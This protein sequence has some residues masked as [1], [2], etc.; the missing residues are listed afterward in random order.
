V[1]AA[2]PESCDPIDS[3]HL[4]PAHSRSLPIG[5]HCIALRVE[6]SQTVYCSCIGGVLPCMRYSHVA[7]QPVPRWDG[8]GLGELQRSKKGGPAYV[9]C[10]MDHPPRM[11]LDN[12]HVNAMPTHTE[13]HL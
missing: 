13:C 8:G 10:L 5:Q 12:T 1:S 9:S 11:K 4:R 7:V 2:M 3:A 6:C